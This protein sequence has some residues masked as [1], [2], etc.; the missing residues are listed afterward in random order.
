M[1]ALSMQ[2]IREMMKDYLRSVPQTQL[3][4]LNDGSELMNLFGS[5][6]TPL[7]FI[8]DDTELLRTM[9]DPFN[10]TGI[11]LDWLGYEVGLSR[12]EAVKSS[13]EVTIT[14]PSS[15]GYDVTYPFG[16][17]ISTGGLSPIVFQT[18][19]E[20]VIP[21]GETSID[22]NVECLVAG[23]QG[24]VVISEINMMVSPV[25]GD[26]SITNNLAFTNG[27]DSESDEEFRSRILEAGDNNVVGTPGWY[28][29]EAKGISGV[30]D[31]ECVEN[32]FGSN[33][34]V[35]YVC[36]DIRPTLESIITSVQALVEAEDGH[37]ASLTPLVLSAN[38]VEADITFS[39]LVLDPT[40][41]EE[42]VKENIEDNITAY[43]YGGTTSYGTYYPGLGIGDNLIYTTLITI[44]GSTPG[45]LTFNLSSPG[46]DL[47]M[48]ESDCIY[49]GDITYP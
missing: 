42:L 6:A 15:L 29:S 36:G 48:G 47:T 10:A 26:E 40:Y 20:A 32:Y 14:I 24:N 3:T 46:N 27:V 2:E 1:T 31:A 38:F 19:D 9:R 12:E 5:V 35:V 17:Y 34:V 49:L 30:F 22:V 13:G 43:L 25:T 8:V 41:N 39:S 33:K 23:T 37:I 16:S 7:K 4:D 18:L 11:W 28:E 45:I 44:I 21:A